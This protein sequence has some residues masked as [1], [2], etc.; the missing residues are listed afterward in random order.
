MKTR[1]LANHK[2]SVSLTNSSRFW[3]SGTF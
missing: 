1:N 2:S 3:K